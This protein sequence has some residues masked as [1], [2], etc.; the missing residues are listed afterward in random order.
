MLD[1]YEAR[2]PDEVARY[3]RAWPQVV[4]V[5]LDA[6]RVVPHYFG[7]IAAG[8]CPTAVLDVVVDPGG[9]DDPVA[10]LDGLTETGRSNAE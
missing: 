2:D 7:P 9:E 10:L 6:A 3:L 8:P 4:P 5:L 1:R